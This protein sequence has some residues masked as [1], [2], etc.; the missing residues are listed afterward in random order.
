ML[1][2]RTQVLKQVAVRPWIAVKDGCVSMV[3]SLKGLGRIKMV[4]W[5]GEGYAERTPLDLG[6]LVLVVDPLLQLAL[7]GVGELADV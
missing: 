4:R 6:F 2:L 5:K 7:F 1:V 3:S